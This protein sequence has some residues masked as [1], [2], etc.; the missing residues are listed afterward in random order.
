MP[1][2]TPLCL[3]TVFPY[4]QQVQTIVQA[5][6]DLRASVSG[7]DDDAGLVKGDM[8]MPDFVLGPFDDNAVAHGR[9]PAQV[10]NALCKALRFFK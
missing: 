5:I 10:C 4:G 6:A 3:Q 9:T 1:C 7:E 2:C 8:S